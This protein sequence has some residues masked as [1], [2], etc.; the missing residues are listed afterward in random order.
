MLDKRA[1][2][3]HATCVVVRIAAMLLCSFWQQYYDMLEF[4]CVSCASATGLLQSKRH[5]ECYVPTLG[6]AVP[7]TLDGSVK[8]ELI[9]MLREKRSYINESV[10]Y[11]SLFSS[12]IRTP[13][14]F[15]PSN[16]AS[17]KLYCYHF[18]TLG[19]N[20]RPL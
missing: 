3:M 15:F 2:W 20:K 12:M 7:S 16:F 8:V 6:L 5:N 11:L 14:H 17:P 18:R 13:G 19:T 10:K 9:V 1:S 4:D